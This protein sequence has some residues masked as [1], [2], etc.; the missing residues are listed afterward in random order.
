MA[1]DKGELDLQARSR[2]RSGCRSCPPPRRATAAR[3]LGAGRAAA[4]E[5]TLGRCLFNET[6]PVDYPFVNYEVPRSS[7][8]IVN[9][10]AERYPKVEVAATLDALKAPASTGPPGPAS[11]S[12]S[13]TS[14][15]RR[16][17]REILEATR[18]RPTRCRSST[19]AV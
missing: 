6:L 12:A 4:V 14:S 15:R 2:S 10:L 9:D 3:G 13:T 17:R 8:A 1:Y 16:T 19:S 7:S 11:R 18:S 5:T